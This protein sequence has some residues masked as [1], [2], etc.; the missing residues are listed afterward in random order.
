MSAKSESLCKHLK[1]F[2]CGLAF[3]NQE[4]QECLQE[5]CHI[6]RSVDFP[7]ADRQPSMSLGA[8]V[9]PSDVATDVF[10]KPVHDFGCRAVDGHF[11]GYGSRVVLGSHL[12][13]TFAIKHPCNV[14]KNI[15]IA[16]NLD[17]WR[18]QALRARLDAVCFKRP[19]NTASANPQIYS[20][21]AVR[22]SSTVGGENL[23]DYVAVP[24]C[25]R[26]SSW[27]ANLHA[28]LAQRFKDTL[29][30]S[31]VFNGQFG[32]S[33]AVFIKLGGFLLVDFCLGLF[34]YLH[35]PNCTINADSWK[36]FITA[37]GRILD[38]QT[39][40]QFPNQEAR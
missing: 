10:A 30:A 23:L 25:N 13:V 12:K 14:A 20:D 6:L 21:L 11:A 29:M 9:I 33:C 24:F 4:R 27:R 26:A 38:G 17:S 15:R 37:A 1:G 31:V 22:N 16:R 35:M 8:L 5:Q 2:F 18:S 39:W 32:R 36:E 28:H 40:D 19:I 3:D 7:N 34:G